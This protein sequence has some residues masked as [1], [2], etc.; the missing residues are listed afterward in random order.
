RFVDSCYQNTQLVDGEVDRVRN[1]TGEVFGYGG[2]RC[3]VTV[4]E[5]GQFVEQTK[6]R[7]LVTFVGVRRIDQAAAGTT[8]H[9]ETDD[10][11]TDHRDN[12][13]AQNQ[14]VIDRANSRLSADFVG[15]ISQG[16]Q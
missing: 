8:I 7:C 3:Q 13:K 4:C 2:R 1:R 5:V 12:G 9:G 6:N 15:N 10:P 11:Q 14:T 16:L